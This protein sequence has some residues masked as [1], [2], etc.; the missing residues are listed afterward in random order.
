M[1]AVICQT[2]G[3]TPKTTNELKEVNRMNLEKEYELLFDNKV[4]E[5]ILNFVVGKN[6]LQNGF[7]V[8][9]EKDDQKK[10]FEICPFSNNEINVV[11]T[12][13]ELEPKQAKPKPKPKQQLQ[14]NVE[15]EFC[16]AVVVDENGKFSVL[17]KLEEYKDIVR[18]R[19][20]QKA[21]ANTK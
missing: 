5:D 21:Q 12:K 3:S 14:N 10:F 11:E 4:Y 6:K 16:S 17:K 2:K 15:T 1:I 7:V 13:P 8:I 18:Q 20:E 9:L 19:E